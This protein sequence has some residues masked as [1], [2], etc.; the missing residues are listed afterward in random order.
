VVQDNKVVDE[1]VTLQSDALL[2]SGDLTHNGTP[3][4]YKKL[5]EIL[6]PIE[7]DIFVIHWSVVVVDPML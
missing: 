6:S 4:S 7:T 3:Y 2:I 1:I 5:K